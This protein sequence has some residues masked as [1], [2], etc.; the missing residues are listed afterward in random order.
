MDIQTVIKI[1]FYLLV[2][3]YFIF[4]AGTFQFRSLK[5]KTEALVL[6][7]AN[8]WTESGSINCQEF[9]QSIYPEWCE[10]VRESA[11]FIPSKSELRPIRASIQNVENRL[12]FSPRWINDYFVKQGLTNLQ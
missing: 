12:G 5:R 9:Y 10:I 2:L 3:W 1:G 4:L 6:M 7:K 8:G 11:L